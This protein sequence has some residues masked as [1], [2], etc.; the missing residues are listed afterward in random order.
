[1]EN[2]KQKV[3]DYP[4]SADA[5]YEYGLALEEHRLWYQALEQYHIAS[6]MLQEGYS[7]QYDANVLTNKIAEITDLVMKN[8]QCENEEFHHNGLEFLYC[9]SEHGWGVRN[10]FH[11]ETPI[12]GDFF[13]DYYE[14]GALYIAKN[15]QIE[16][17][18]T[19]CNRSSGS[20]A[21]DRAELRRVVKQC[22]EISFEADRD[23]YV[24]VLTEEYARLNITN[25]DKTDEVFQREDQQ[26]ITYKLPAGNNCI[27]ADRQ[28]VIGELIPAT[29]FDGNKKLVMGIFIDGLTQ[30]IIDED[31]EKIMPYTYRFFSKGMM[32][33]NVYTSGDWT[34]PA[35]TSIH[36]GQGTP[37]HKMIHPSILRK[38][39]F[40]TPMLAEYLKA[41]GYNTSK[42]GGNWRITPNYGY[43]RGFNRTVYQHHYSGYWAEEIIA[44]VED[45][46]YN[47]K[48]TD[49]FIW[50]E[51]IELHTAAD[52]VGLGS[53]VPNVSLNKNGFPAMQDQT[54]VKQAYD[55][56]QRA[57]Y[58]EKLKKIDRRLASL[59]AFIEDNYSEDEILITLIS[60]HGQGFLIEPGKDFFEDKRS[61]VPFMIRGN[62]RRGESKELMSVCDYTAIICN[63][64]GI[65]FDYSNTDANLPKT[66]GGLE[67]RDFTVTES[68]H[69]GDVYQLRITGNEFDFYLHS[70]AK[71]TSDCRVDLSA[72]DAALLD[73]SGNELNNEEF[74]ET[75]IEFT[76]DHLGTCLIDR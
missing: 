75:C 13:R 51:L 70:E 76:F 46:I 6:I 7:F 30:K 25:N 67:E 8:A 14:L 28:M 74:K 58:L 39:D 73:K 66:F 23:Y 44:D 36:T 12:I 60:D 40:D 19:C 61:R 55:E 45:Q 62:G 24:P 50:M 9:Q 27:Q 11:S 31:M 18:K 56:T 3:R 21:I 68:I 54:S 53:E 22:N 52:N 29:H 16:S 5:H 59:F 69:P 33:K 4:Y 37:R 43:A 26:F 17:W 72:F 49:Q 15:G 41:A 64:L 63:E 2:A 48:D 47:M 65:Q 34:Y 38:I 35:M 57:F 71:V 1:M 32:C 10:V 20:L 42:F